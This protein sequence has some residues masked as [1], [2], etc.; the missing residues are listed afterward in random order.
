MAL[1]VLTGGA[2][3]GKSELAVKAA[4]ASGLAVAVIATAEA[5]DPEFALRIRRHRAGRPSGWTVVEEPLELERA[6]CRAPGYSFMIVDCISLWV[7]NLL[8]QGLTEDEL[9]AA[10]RAAAAAAAGRPAP[11]VA[12][13]NEVGWGIV[14]AN[15]MARQYRV[16]LG[17]ANRA[18]V[19]ASTEAWLVVAGRA[20]RL[21]E[22]AA[23]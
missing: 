21:E 16:V 12:V 17:R 13:T 10:A 14:P 1:T 3:S 15:P 6:I 19:E 20:L 9:V 22:W 11:S 23:A 4:G 5:R 8:E 18:W 2:R 7:A